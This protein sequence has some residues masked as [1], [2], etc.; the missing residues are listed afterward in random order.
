LKLKN[1][2]PELIEEMELALCCIAAEGW[3]TSPIVDHEDFA[4]V[5]KRA[6]DVL[7]KIRQY[8]G[9]KKIPVK[10]RSVSNK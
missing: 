3:Q 7:Y 10:R 1:L 2:S 4:F 9:I 6:R 8:T 5:Q